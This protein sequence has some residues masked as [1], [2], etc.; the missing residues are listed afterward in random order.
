MELKFELDC[1][2]N[3]LLHWKTHHCLSST[4]H[5]LCAFRP[6]IRTQEKGM[7]SPSDVVKLLQ[8]T[9]DTQPIEACCTS[10]DANQW[11]EG[12]VGVQIRPEAKKLYWKI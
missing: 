10:D 4:H 2:E 5:H 6:T 9:L 12:T 7:S 1:L 11:P 3:A 8:D